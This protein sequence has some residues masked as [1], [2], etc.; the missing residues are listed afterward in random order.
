MFINKKHTEN[1]KKPKKEYSIWIFWIVLVLIIIVILSYILKSHKKTPDAVKHDI[2]TVSVTPL[3]YHVIPQIVTGY[4][5]TYSPDSVSLKSPISAM[6]DKIKFKPGDK[7]TKG[8][9]LFLLKNTVLDNSQEVLKAK[10]YK[11]KQQYER[12]IEQ[13]KLFKNSIAEMDLINYKT[14]YQQAKSAYDK[15]NDLNAIKSPING[16]ISATD[17]SEG[18]YVNAGDDLVTITEF[19]NK[20]SLQIQ[21]ILPSIYINQAKIGQSVSFGLVGPHNKTHT[22][23]AKV[24]YVSPDVNTNSQGVTL[25]A[26]FINKFDDANKLAPN[27]FGKI[28]QVINPSYKTLAVDQAFVQ[29]D[30][31][32]FYIY[33]LENNKVVKH[34]FEPSFISKSGLIAVY[35]GLQENI[36]IITTDPDKITPGEKVKIKI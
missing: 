28:T 19:V 7:I 10:L 29:S 34:Y 21:Y 17:L 2:Q 13:N 9:V 8:E 5:A 24:S 16:I 4:G 33:S 31:E 36:Q 25:R 20:N 27:V 6:I 30:P 35:S 1:L 14:D 3:T 22:Y 26:D 15:F 32:G 18:D 12:S 11:A 23:Q